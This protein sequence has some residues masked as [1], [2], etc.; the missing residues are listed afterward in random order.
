MAGNVFL[1]LPKM[2]KSRQFF[3]FFPLFIPASTRNATP[4]AEAFTCLRAW[5][6]LAEL[7]FRRCYLCDLAGYICVRC[8]PRALNGALLFLFCM[9]YCSSLSGGDSVVTRIAFAT[10]STPPSP[11]AQ[12]PAT[13][14]PPTPL[15]Q[16]LSPSP[17]FINLVS[18]DSDNDGP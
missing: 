18:S 11:L 16:A 9:S 10:G 7:P 5:G 14:P 12:P 4:G 6:N 8:S 2:G 3:L 15:A 17:S 13:P 1:L